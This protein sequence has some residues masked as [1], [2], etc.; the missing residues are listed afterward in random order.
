MMATKTTALAC[1]LAVCMAVLPSAA[2]A[3][4]DKT[5]PGS[6]TDYQGRKVTRVRVTSPFAF[7]PAA[8][9]GFQQLA[10]TLPLKEGDKFTASAYSRGAGVITET[11]RTSFVDGFS[12]MRF[13]ATLPQLE[14]CTADTVEVH[15]VVYSSVFPPLFGQTFAVRQGA[16]E[17]PATTGG[18]LGTK[19]RF[20]IVPDSGYNHTRRG[21]AGG[22]VQSEMP[23][24]IFDHLKLQASASSNSLLGNIDLNGKRMLAKHYL[25]RAEW[26][27]SSTY[28]DLPA[29]A[30]RLKEAKLAA[31]FFA[32]SKEIA[33]GKPILHY[34]VSLAGG[35]QQGTTLD[36]SN[37][38]YGD[39]KA[40]GGLE[41]QQ[42][43]GAFSA[44]YGLQLGSTLNDRT[45]DFAKHII[46]LRYNLYFSPL[47][48]FLKTQKEPDD[49]ACFIGKTHKP[50]SLEGQANAGIIQAFG[51]VPA[52]ERF[53]GGNRESA[54]F[55]ENQPW[56]VRG[57]PYIR[58]IP[59]NQIGS[60]NPAFGVGG[61]R[62]YSLNMTLAKVVMGRSLLPKELGDQGFVDALDGGIATAKLAT[63]NTYLAQDPEVVKAREA[64]KGAVTALATE[65]KK[66]KTALPSFSFGQP[67][68]AQIAGPLKDLKTKSTTTIAITEVILDKGNATRIPYLMDTLTPALLADLDKIKAALTAPEHA[69]AAANV[70]A[71]RDA[72]QAALDQLKTD[73]VPNPAARARASAQADQD[74]A[75]AEKVLN[76]LL[77]QLNIYSVAPVGIFDVA[78]V[79]PSGVGVRYGLGG[80]VRVSLVNANFTIGYAANPV[81]SNKEG[82]GALFFKLDV[83]NIFH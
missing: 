13:V 71:L 73:W 58:S 82:P 54:P 53:F 48:L 11:V 27:L 63:L 29:G 10:A 21:Y 57:E 16:V 43:V 28:S 33:P 83:T 32:Q 17:K 60:I 14:N 45:V 51:A 3:Q 61:T 39:L 35:H 41:S 50:F 38:S 18:S 49:R 46:D 12:A 81:R 62:F 76:T 80:G 24:S 36:A 44:S 59:E 37:S 56:D 8:S 5:C 52:A 30:F 78:R 19:G 67:V 1:M 9:Y 65:V 22:L 15:Y 74:L 6:P 23:V 40:V 70:G 79:W 66:L 26:H 75:T 2:A 42:G 7:F 68:D 69:A 72:L 34:A 77:Y 25:D 4:G 55:I 47:P 64:A 31:S 20:L